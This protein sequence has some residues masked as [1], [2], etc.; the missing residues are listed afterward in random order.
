M[1][2]W[3]TF[4]RPESA[5]GSQKITARA[6]RIEAVRDSDCLD[7]TAHITMMSGAD[8]WVTGSRSEILDRIEAT[9]WA[10]GA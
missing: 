5:S 2:T 1:K 10:D 8:F 3:L 4:D 7:G 6:D 9:R